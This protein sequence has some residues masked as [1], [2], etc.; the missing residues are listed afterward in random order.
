MESFGWWGFQQFVVMWWFGGR[1]SGGVWVGEEMEG[2][3]G[4]GS[5]KGEAE[6]ETGRGKGE[7]GEERMSERRLGERG[8][9][10]VLSSFSENSFP[11]PLF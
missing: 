3:K 9:G 5:G 7:R 11:F 8:R 2:R 1:V 10:R 6:R 4:R